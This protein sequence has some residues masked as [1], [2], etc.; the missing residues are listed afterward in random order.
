L[1]CGEFSFLSSLYILLSVL[2]LN[3]FLIVSI[4]KISKYSTIIS[5]V[6]QQ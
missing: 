6:V 2:C 1:I 3:A 5:Y 4:I